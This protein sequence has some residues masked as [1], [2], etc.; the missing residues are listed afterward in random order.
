MGDR[1]VVCDLDGT[2]SD[3]GHRIHLF[4]E[5]DYEAFNAAGINDR[6]IENICNI[7]RELHG[8]DTE[9]VIMTARDESHRRDT[10]KWLR[11]NDVPCDRLIMRPKDDQSSDDVCKLKLMQ[12]HIPDYRDIWFVLEDRKSVVD[13]WRGEGITC[14]QVAPGDF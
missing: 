1:I 12:K 7:L 14:L 11:L 4:K 6:P 13:M 8:K 9:V 10:A 2:L 5:R 3:Y